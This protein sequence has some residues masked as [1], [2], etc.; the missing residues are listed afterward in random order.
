M[1]IVKHWCR[2]WAIHR[3]MGLPCLQANCSGPCTCRSR[4]EW[5]CYIV[6]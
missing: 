2:M 4:Q 5:L 6:V 1:F 3:G